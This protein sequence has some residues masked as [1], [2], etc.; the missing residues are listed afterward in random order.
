MNIVGVKLYLQGK[1]T[2][3]GVSISDGKIAKI[4]KESTLPP[5]S[6]T[7][8][9]HRLLALP[10]LVDVHAHLRD[11][12]LSYKEDYFSGTS[13][14]AAGGFTTL[15]DMPNTSP[16]TDSAERLRE[17][18]DIARRKIVV[19]VGFN[20]VPSNLEEVTKAKELAV[21]YK[22]NLVKPWSDLSLDD[23]T[24]TSLINR[25]GLIGKMVI[26]H[27]EDGAM[28]SR[29]ENEFKE[30]ASIQSYYRAHPPEAEDVAVARVLGCTAE[31]TKIH[32]CHISSVGSLRLI[33]TAKQQRKKITCEVTPHH[34]FLS[35]ER[36]SKWG[37]ISIMDPP[38]R[39]REVAKRLFSALKK[40]AID[41]VGTDHAPHSIGEKA[42]LPW[43]KIPPGIPG[44][45]TALPL[46]LTEV[47]RGNISLKRVIE[48]MAET[49]AEIFGLN[50]GK[51][52]EGNPADIIL[53]D[54]NRRFKID[55]S[56]FFSKA[57]YSPFDGRGVVGKIVKTFVGGK[58]V[59]DENRIVE[60][61]GAGTILT[62][63]NTWAKT[64]DVNVRLS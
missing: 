44:L 50:R 42:Q 19:N 51:L 64:C 4:G 30:N 36:A 49:P 10:G 22:I 32:F 37:G 54:L 45:E 27:A 59:F 63:K 52:K 43:W 12:E 25:A 33:K 13:A 39:N 38:L 15:I 3:G 34:L 9:G 14:A 47:K 53:V 29:L 41:I 16:V 18:M 58:L 56:I 11:L 23:S 57:K 1:L 55:S 8:Q 60:A 7:L 35:R 17:K 28:V 40:R 2:E 5:S 31:Q 20:I 46:L 24:L 6:K 62:P 21:G 26:F 61:P 48:A